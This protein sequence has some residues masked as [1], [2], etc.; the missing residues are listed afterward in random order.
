VRTALRFA[1]TSI[2]AACSLIW[3]VGAETA[4]LRLLCAVAMKPVLDELAPGFEQATSNKI[5]ITYGTAGVV[6][7]KIRNGE[8]FDVAVLPTPFMDPLATQGAVSS[9]SV[10]VLARSLI[11]VAVRT[12]SPKPDISTVAAFKNAMLAAKSISYADPAQ[13]GGSG[14]QVARI[15]EALGIADA[16]KTK[17]K[18]VPGA[19]SV[20]LV[21]NGEA[22]IAMLNTPVIVVKA[23]VDLVGAIPSELYDIKDFAF[24]IGIG[25]NAKEADAARA[26]IR[27]LSTSDAARVFK[28]KGV[29][30]GA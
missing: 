3:A 13:G 20:D 23:G 9:A 1:A 28:A 8:P 16:M 19:Q 21:A 15:L 18:L 12:G 2:V 6:R 11:S 29:E 27:Y 7:D 25:A 24:K 5:I 26:L 14:I 17:T 10:V 4:E 22:E 30:P